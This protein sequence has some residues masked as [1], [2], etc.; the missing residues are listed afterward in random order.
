MSSSAPNAAPGPPILSQQQD[1]LVLLNSLSFRRRTGPILTA[2]EL[3]QVD[4]LMQSY[5]DSP[6]SRSALSKNQMMAAVNALLPKGASMV[7]AKFNKSQLAGALQRWTQEAA[8][9]APPTLQEKLFIE[10]KFIRGSRKHVDLSQAIYIE[11]DDGSVAALEISSPGPNPNDRVDDIPLSQ[12][13]ASF[14]P[15]ISPIPLDG[16]PFSTA[17]SASSFARRMNGAASFQTLAATETNDPGVPE[18]NVPPPGCPCQ[19]RCAI[20]TSGLV[21]P[22]SSISLTWKSL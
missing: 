1:A 3:K 9:L 2:D 18:E 11:Q 17:T 16:T 12:S 15:D 13:A 20:F 6:A 19:R 14:L 21:C 5:I 22:V 7:S 4:K 10:L 8:E